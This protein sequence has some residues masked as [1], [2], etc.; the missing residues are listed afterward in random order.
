VHAE[1]FFT[2]VLQYYIELGM[3]RTGM[4]RFSDGS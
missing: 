2:S 1:I 3:Q 4:H